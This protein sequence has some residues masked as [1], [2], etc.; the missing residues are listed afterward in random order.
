MQCQSVAKL[1]EGPQWLYEVKQ[2][3]YRAEALIDG[4]TA[5]KRL[6]VQQKA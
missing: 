6:T 4:N 2:D 1:P 3:G 5:W